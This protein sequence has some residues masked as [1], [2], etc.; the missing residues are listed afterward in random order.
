MSFRHRPCCRFGCGRSWALPDQ[1]VC[2]R[3]RE[4]TQMPGAG[5]SSS[6]MELIRPEAIGGACSF[7]EERRYRL[8]IV[9]R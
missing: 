1:A 6:M 5:I 8:A 3:F 2:E 7:R 9:M 4:T